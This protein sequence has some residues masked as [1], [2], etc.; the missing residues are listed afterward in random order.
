MLSK[1]DSEIYQYGVHAS[2]NFFGINK[3]SDGAGNNQHFTAAQ[4]S[5]DG[6]I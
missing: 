4:T 3:K 6:G 5:R 2:H 1:D